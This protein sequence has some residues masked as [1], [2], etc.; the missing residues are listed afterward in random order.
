METQQPPRRKR[1]TLI[2]GPRPELK[3]LTPI[4]GVEDL[5]VNVLADVTIEQPPGLTKLVKSFLGG[6]VRH[7]GYRVTSLAFNTYWNWNVHSDLE[8]IYDANMVILDLP[9]N[10]VVREEVAQALATTQAIR[11]FFCDLP[12]ERFG[13]HH[14]KISDLLQEVTSNLRGSFIDWVVIDTQAISDDKF[15]AESHQ[16]TA[17]GIEDLQKY[18]PGVLICRLGTDPKE[19]RYDPDCV[20]DALLKIM[21]LGRIE[22]TFQVK[23]TL[24]PVG[25][26]LEEGLPTR[27]DLQ[28]WGQVLLI[29]L[30]RSEGRVIASVEGAGGTLARSTT[31]PALVASSTTL[32]EDWPLPQPEPRNLAVLTEWETDFLNFAFYP[33]GPVQEEDPPTTENLRILGQ[34]LLVALQRSEGRVIASVEGAGGTLARST[35]V[36]ALMAAGDLAPRETE[37]LHLLVSGMHNPD[38]GRELFISLRTVSGHVSSLF[39]KTGTSNREQLIA[40]AIRQNLVP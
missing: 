22:G 40:Y 20:C 14:T 25:R 10:G 23:P 33:L 3:R 36:P 12:L 19:F 6:V 15:L 2:E 30:Q 34:V 38:I 39:R 29:A 16:G 1:V 37:V 11:I 4:E 17:Y 13:D 27:G 32:P 24:Y 7:T 26:V 28:A 8:I 9:Q 35:T 18:V 21:S 31:V 5:R